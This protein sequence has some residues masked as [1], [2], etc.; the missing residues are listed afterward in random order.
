[1]LVDVASAKAIASGME[2][3]A[4]DAELRRRLALAGRERALALYHIDTAVNRYEAILTRAG[5]DQV[6]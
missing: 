4:E 1:M 5:E 3:M 2:A 6:Q